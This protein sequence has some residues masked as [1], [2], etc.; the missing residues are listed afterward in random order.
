MVR[1]ELQP[2]WFLSVH[3]QSCRTR[4]SLGGRFG[5][6]RT[7]LSVPPA[8]SVRVDGLSVFPLSAGGFDCVTSAQCSVARSPAR[9]RARESAG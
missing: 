5:V 1:R 3:Q 6:P 2:V 4:V 8:C 7:R 9:S